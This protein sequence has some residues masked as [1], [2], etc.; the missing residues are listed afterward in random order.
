M[1][2]KQF[3][4]RFAKEILEHE[5][6]LEHYTELITICRNAP[7]PIYQGLS[8]TQ[9]NKD[10]V[11]QLINTY[12]KLAFA[13][14][15]WTLEPLVTPIHEIDTLRG[16][17]RKTFE[18]P[19]KT[20]LTAQIEVEMG[21]I[22]SSYRNYFKFQLSYSHGLTDICVLILP[23]NALSKRID[24]GVA[25][26]EKTVREIPSAKLSITV[27]ILVIG[28]SSDTIWNLREIYPERTLDV[29][30]NLKGALVENRLAHEQIIRDYIGTRPELN[31][32]N[33]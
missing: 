23:D 10:V 7:T 32:N 33:L 29:I 24:S 31:T 5:D 28:L 4:Y 22:A 30:K 26:F 3:S 17:F 1:I 19:G 16:D 13:N 2:I 6:H 14:K 15:E 11:Q 9:P 8:E 21:N 25:S 27:P 12:F 20:N 18:I